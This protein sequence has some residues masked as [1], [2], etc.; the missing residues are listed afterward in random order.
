MDASRN[1]RG[2]A[3]SRAAAVTGA[4]ANS[5]IT[6]TGAKCARSPSASNRRSRASRRHRVRSARE[7]SCRRAVAATIRGPAQLSTTIRNFSATVQRRRPVSVT[8]R[9]SIRD[10]MPLSA[11]ASGSCRKPVPRVRRPSPDEYKGRHF[12]VSFQNRN[13]S[14]RTCAQNGRIRPEMAGGGRRRV[15]IGPGTGRCE[16]TRVAA[17]LAKG[18]RSSLVGR[19]KSGELRHQSRVTP[20]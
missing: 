16:I 14:S 13:P 8:A 15:Q 18:Q 10:M 12:A 11:I 3:Q 19:T 20:Y 5:V 9:T 4:G 2:E 7:I 1:D 6:A 17:D